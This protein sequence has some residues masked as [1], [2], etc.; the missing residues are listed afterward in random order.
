MNVATQAAKPTRCEGCSILVGPGYLSEQGWPAP[1]GRGILCWSCRDYLD[2]A[3]ARGRDVLQVLNSWR[4]DLKTSFV[5]S[6]FL[7]SRVG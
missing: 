4:R 5:S 1:D 3:A 2:T 7:Y 6:P